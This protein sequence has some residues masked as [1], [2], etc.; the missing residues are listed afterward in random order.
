MIGRACL[1]RVKFSLWECSGWM[2]M[3]RLPSIPHFFKT[4]HALR[5]ILLMNLSHQSLG[6][7]QNAQMGLLSVPVICLF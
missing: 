4:T 5:I 7:T 3:A 6:G 2:A 1:T